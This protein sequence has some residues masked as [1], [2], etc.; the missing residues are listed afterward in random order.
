[1]NRPQPQPQEDLCPVCGD[2]IEAGC[3]G[4]CY[5]CRLASFLPAWYQDA[6]QYCYDRIWGQIN[7]T[8]KPATGV[9]LLDATPR[10]PSECLWPRARVPKPPSEWKPYWR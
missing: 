3:H 5:G 7:A 2:G 1:M 4:V 9:P 10:R 8:R 6:E